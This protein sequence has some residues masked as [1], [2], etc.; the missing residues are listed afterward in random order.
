MAFD[1]QLV[2]MQTN[3]QKI[4]F[5]WPEEVWIHLVTMTAAVLILQ[6]DFY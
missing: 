2:N 1:T 6:R 3:M 4:I 5:G